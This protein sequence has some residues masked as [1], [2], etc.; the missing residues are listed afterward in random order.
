[1]TMIDEYMNYTIKSY[2]EFGEKTVVLIQVGSFFEVYA[3]KDEKNEYY[4]QKKPMQINSN[5]EEVSKICELAVTGKPKCTGKPNVSMCGFGLAQIDKYINKLQNNNYTIVIYTQDFQGANAT[6][7]LSQI[8]SP[9][10]FFGNDETQLSNNTMCIW[11]YK[12]VENKLFDSSITIGISNIDI[13]TGKTNIFQYEVESY[14][15]SCTYDDLEKHVSIYKPSECIFITN[16]IEHELD[17]IIDFVN[18]NSSKTHKIILN[19][20]SE[21]SKKAHNAEKQTYQIAVMNKY[22]PKLSEES[23][24]TM[25]PSHYIA[26]QSF[27]FL[28]DF[29]YLH[30]PNLVHKLT[31]PEF[32]NHSDNLI[33]ANHSLTQLNML[34]DSRHVGKNKSVN[35][36]LNNCVTTMGKRRFIHTLNNPLTQIDILNE[37]YDITDHLLR[38]E[39]N[40][41]RTSLSEL[42]DVEKFYRRLVLKKIMP[43]DLALMNNDFDIVIQMDEMI[44][45]DSILHE[46]LKKHKLGDINDR[47]LKIKKILNDNFSLKKCLEIDDLSPD[48]LTRISSENISFICPDKNELI[49]DL[50][51]KSYD[52]IKKLEAISQV[53][54]DMVKNVEKKTKMTTTNYIKIHETPKNDPVLI[55]TKRRIVLLETEI[56][57]LIKNKTTELDIHYKSTDGSESNFKLKIDDLNHTTFGSN[58]KDL[59]ISNSQIREIGEEIQNSRDKLIQEIIIHFNKFIQEFIQN[60]TDIE[61][62]IDAIIQM[63]LLQNK[64][65]IAHTFNYC[66][67]V[68]Q[69]SNKSFIKLKEIRHPLIEHIQTRELYVT[70]DIEIG[71][72]MNGL[73]LYGTNAVGKTSF[74]KSIGIAV[75]MAQAGLFVPCSEFIYHPYSYIFTR[76]LGNDN[77]FK[78]LSTFAVEMS[79]LRTILKMADK[80]SLVLGDELCSGTESDSALSIFTAGLEILHNKECSFLFATHFHEVSNYD[81]ILNLNKLKM[82]HM[83]VI[84]DRE[85]K[86]LVYNRKLQDGPGESMYG[87]EVCKSLHLPDEFLDRAHNIRTKYNSMTNNI[88]SQKPSHYNAKKIKDI[89]ELCNIQP[90]SEVHHLRHQNNARKDNNYIDTHHKNHVANLINICETCHDE[91]HKTG[92]QHRIVKTTDGYKLIATQRFNSIQ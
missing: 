48:G 91:I 14:H 67:P 51:N 92:D 10:T 41:Y 33:L 27:T 69:K 40:K 34:D 52:N 57:K 29:I 38:N 62:I 28:L 37:S 46:Y 89:C 56:K 76:I 9:G 45:S 49:T 60:Q 36:L 87:L 39:W 17:E 44:K 81:E 64:C 13:Y 55:G 5:I 23:F 88:L 68:I 26:I 71:N 20:D 19:T 30:N 82:M 2:E 21:N 59:I 79:E 54:S 80:N 18:V 31:L 83:Q 74:I 25:F 73:L 8:I 24:M 4:I 12:M 72:E 84:Y 42:K 53:L 43:K 6:R 63:D 35:S 70:N 66:K 77:L 61:V 50:I 3:L 75:I 7:S 47:C 86:C 11:I 16:M 65:Y 78:G 15:N 22:F 58:K 1:M 90:A 32:A 85:N